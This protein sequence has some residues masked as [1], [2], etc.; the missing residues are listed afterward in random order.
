VIDAMQSVR[1]RKQ[2]IFSLF[3]HRAIFTRSRS[4]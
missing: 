2:F 4:Y 3:D 1:Q